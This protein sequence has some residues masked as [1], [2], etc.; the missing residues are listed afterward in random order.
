MRKQ[1]WCDDEELTLLRQRLEDEGGPACTLVDLEVDHRESERGKKLRL[2]IAP[3]MYGDFVAV[4]DYFANRPDAIAK[5][6]QRL[7]QET[8]R[9]LV[10]QA[11]PS[12]IAVN[13][14]VTSAD[15]YFLALQ[16]SSA[17]RK[18][19][20]QWGLGAYETMILPT[21]RPGESEDFFGA[22]QRCLREEVGLEPG[23]DY[24]DII[25]SWM[26]YW[27]SS[28]LVHVI[29]HVRSTLTAADI[30]RRVGESYSSFETG[31][32]LWI[33]D[34]KAALARL[35]RDHPHDGSNRTWIATAPIAAQQ[36]WRCRS[37]LE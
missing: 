31:S 3:S 35:V 16:R 8:T 25:V 36:Y 5:V 27:I 21:E 24:G 28:A 10:Q 7:E 34:S 22:T 23:Q 20:N 30:G 11:P 33:P 9:D 12:I 17:V 14:T 37:L 18:W 26:G 29:A 19:Q 32:L 4:H 13:A 15:G 1:T 6:Q 2:T